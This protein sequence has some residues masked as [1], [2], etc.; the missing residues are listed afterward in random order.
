[1]AKQM[2]TR[3]SQAGLV[4]GMLTLLFTSATAQADELEVTNARLSILPGDRPGAGYFQLYNAS[5]EV[6]TL[7]GAESA[8]FENVEMHV[9]SEQDG[10]AHMHEIPSLEIAPGEHVEF[11]P[12]GYHLMFMRRVAPLAEGDDVDV[13]LEFSDQQ[14]LSVSF[15]VVS[16]TSL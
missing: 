4:L 8:A 10:M 13:L 14:P 12:K 1:M 11:A 16:P 5:D 15:D 9:S 7:V 3:V 2:R 6:V